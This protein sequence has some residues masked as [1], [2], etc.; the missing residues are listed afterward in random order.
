MRR[1]ARVAH[2]KHDGGGDNGP[3][4]TVVH[5]ALEYAEAYPDIV[6]WLLVGRYTD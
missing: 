1:R 6:R 4:A 2:V 3:E 5:N